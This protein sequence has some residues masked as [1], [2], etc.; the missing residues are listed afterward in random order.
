MIFT[1]C[2][3]CISHKIIIGDNSNDEECHAFKLTEILDKPIRV[4]AGYYAN[5]LDLFL[6]SSR[7]KNVL[8]KLYIFWT[9]HCHN[10]YYIEGFLRYL[11][12]KKVTFRL[13]F[14]E[15]SFSAF[16]RGCQNNLPHLRMGPF[17]HTASKYQHRLNRKVYN[18]M[19]CSYSPP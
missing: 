3:F 1:F 15:A 8:L 18:Q 4:R 10:W 2:M 17:R 7:E 6:S 16:I 11:N 14:A 9:P 19:C 13:Y 12:I 5:V